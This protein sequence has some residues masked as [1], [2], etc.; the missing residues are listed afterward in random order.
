MTAYDGASKYIPYHDDSY[1]GERPLTR[2]EVQQI[3]EDATC[4]GNTA[5]SINSDKQLGRET[6]LR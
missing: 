4:E 1:R 5:M 2:M 3:S 6:A